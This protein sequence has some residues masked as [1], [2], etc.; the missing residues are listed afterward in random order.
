MLFFDPTTT[1]VIAI[2][3]VVILLYGAYEV[4]VLKRKPPGHS[5]GDGATGGDL[6]GD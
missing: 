6:D 1:V 4:R 3:V 2:V 5:R